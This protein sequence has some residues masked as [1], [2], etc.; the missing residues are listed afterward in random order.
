[1]RRQRPRLLVVLGTPALMAVAPVEKQIPVVFA[2]VGNPYFTGA[3]YFPDH[4]EDHQ[5]NVTGLATPAPLTAALQA[6]GG[7]AG[8]RPLGPPLRSQ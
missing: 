5:E 3:A 2:L 7:L 4:P 1:M 8:G 6:G